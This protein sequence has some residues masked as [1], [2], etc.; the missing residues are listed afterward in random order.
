MWQ[1]KKKGKCEKAP[2]AN[3]MHPR[4]NK[5]LT[6]SDKTGKDR[7][8]C[9]GVRHFAKNRWQKQGCAMWNVEI[10]VHAHLLGRLHRRWCLICW[11]THFTPKFCASGSIICD[12][13]PRWSTVCMETS[14]CDDSISLHRVLLDT[15]ANIAI[16]PELARPPWPRTYLACNWEVP[17]GEQ[18]HFRC[19]RHS[20]RF[21][22][23][24]K[25]FQSRPCNVLQ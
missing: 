8:G 10:K 21:T 15:S 14:H 3:H 1:K 4:Q 2:R 11:K 6:K 9:G 19:F 18:L 24:S 16:F 5:N 23:A 20:P 17:K 25:G 12:W 7:F 22:W 13:W